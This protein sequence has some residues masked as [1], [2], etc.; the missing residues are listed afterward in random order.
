M[1]SGPYRVRA[2]AEGLLESLAP[3]FQPPATWRAR[4][5]A[6][7]NLSRLEPAPLPAD[8]DAGAAGT[9]WPGCGTSTAMSGHRPMKWAWGKPCRPWRC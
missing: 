7:R 6:L 3:D 8:L 9:A 1:G 2:E 5:G 4:S